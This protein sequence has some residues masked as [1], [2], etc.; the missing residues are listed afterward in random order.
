M[1]VVRAIF[2]AKIKRCSHILAQGWS[3]DLFARFVNRKNLGWQ[4]CFPC[5]Y[6]EDS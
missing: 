4:G 1:S 3:I 5:P 2:L 6:G